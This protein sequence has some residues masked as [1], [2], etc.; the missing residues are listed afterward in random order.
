MR[1]VEES[2][3]FS[4]RLECCCMLFL[5]VLFA[6]AQD[7]V[8][9]REVVI[10]SQKT[11]LSSLGKKKEIIDSATLQQYRLRSVAELLSQNSGVFIKSYGPGALATTAFRGG[12]AEQTAI[13]WNGLNMQ[14]YMLGQT[15]LSLLPAMLFDQVGIEYGGSSSVWGSGSVGGSVHLDNK[16]PFNNGL[17]AR[18]TAGAGSFSKFDLSSRV[19]YGGKKFASTTK[20][21]YQ[22][23]ENNFVFGDE[24]HGD[25]K[26]RKK[27]H[28]SY[29]F[30][31]LMQQFRIIVGKN[32]L[33]TADFWSSSNDREIPNVNPGRE[34]KTYQGDRALRGSVSWALETKKFSGNIKAALLND[35]INYRDSLRSSYASS[36]VTTVIAENTNT[37][38]WHPKNQTTLAFNASQSEAGTVNYAT[39]RKVQRASALLADK[40]TLSDSRLNLAGGVRMEYYS[41]GTMPVTWNAG[42]EY[43]PL[44]SLTLRIAAAKLFR[45]PTMNELF[46]TPGGNPGLK[47]EQGHSAD[48]SFNLILKLGNTNFFVGGAVFT[49]TINNWI[50]WLPG[51]AGNP[52][53]KNVQQVWSRGAE[54][55]WKLSRSFEKTRAELGVSSSYVLST[56]MR[57]EQEGTD[58]EGRQLIY[59]PRYSGNG[60]LMITREKWS[61][62]FF[63]QYVGYRFT[64]TD[65]RQWLDPYT[66]S[67]VRI[68]YTAPVENTALDLFF[69]CNNL[70]N[71]SYFVVAGRPMPMRYFEAGFSFYT[72][73]TKT[74]T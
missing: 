39:V 12:S 43:K 35:R 23:S 50:Q 65:N 34:S 59:T 66:V 56:V 74:P 15:D 54:T 10:R 21:Y 18:V 71:G 11:E 48:G 47:P 40:V 25:G 55:T 9:L 41:A 32:Q 30:S 52:T 57:D 36:S 22:S 51:A 72:R 70:F 61:F 1:S 20:L 38:K 73:K 69:G 3:G 27:T 44:E 2:D 4:R 13:L 14:N 46:W 33:V 60:R 29:L 28:N 26:L 58:A 17:N 19:D 62:F 53:P 7:T 6:K 64:T 68:N 42:A 45:Q 49:R 24:T 5:L 31:G 37:F 16:A 8:G 67:S 63:Q